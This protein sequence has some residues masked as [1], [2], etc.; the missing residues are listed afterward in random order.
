MVKEFRDFLMRGNLIELAV[1]V[2]IATALAKLVES[3]TNNLVSPLIAM[4]GGKPDFGSLTFEINGA[5]FRY[6]AFLTDVIAFVIFAAVIFFFIVRPFSRLF[7]KMAPDAGE[8][9]DD[10]LKD[11]RELLRTK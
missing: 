7:A 9:T 4:F 1:A 3:L 10:I 5:V 11:I 6:G 2:L 8:S